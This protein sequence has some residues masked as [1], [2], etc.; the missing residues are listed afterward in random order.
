MIRRLKKITAAL[1]L[2]G[3]LLSSVVAPVLVRAFDVPSILTS[4]ENT[5]RQ[6]EAAAGVDLRTILDAAG[7]NASQ[8]ADCTT[9]A[10]LGNLADIIKN[11]KQRAL[12]AINGF[13][14]DF[15]RRI[16]SSFAYCAAANILTSPG[17]ANPA[18]DCTISIASDARAAFEEA[19]DRE[20]RQNF[21]GRCVASLMMKK[22]VDTVAA[23]MQQSGPYGQGPAW[24]TSWLN[25]PGTEAA[26]ARDRF[27]SMLVNTD[28]CPHM[29]TRVLMYFRVPKSYIDSPPPLT[30]ITGVD[31]LD[32]FPM[33]AA[34]TLPKGFTPENMAVATQGLGY[35]TAVELM[36]RPQ[37]NFEGFIDIAQ[38]EL[39][40]Q[41]DALVTAAM[42]D[43]ISGGGIKSPSDC[44]SWSPD[45]RTC[46]AAGPNKQTGGTL[47]DQNAAAI[48]AQYDWL[49]S[50]DGTQ[51][52]AIQDIRISIANRLFNLANQP[53]PLKIE[54]GREDNADSSQ[55]A[56]PSPTPDVACTGGDPRCTCVRNDESIQALVRPYVADAIARAMFT[57]SELFS[58]NFIAPGVDPRTVLQAIC[59]RLNTATQTSCIPHPGQDDEIVL[60]GG[61][62]TISVHVINSDGSI[63]TSGG[64]AVAA[65]E[66]GVQ[67]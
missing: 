22:S 36:A 7:L 41:T 33:R 1:A 30:G 53:L 29:K 42:A 57:N 51:K 23:F 34:C 16:V 45:G 55:P 35:W 47:R 37:N 65:C 12:D 43:A 66:P 46:L 4:T 25:L 67:D 11:F 64:N 21:I 15:M 27:Y 5:I 18:P 52:K 59:D 40:R 19:K 9:P 17:G 20:I 56:T 60:V 58:G 63:V 6:G 62:T 54:F 44:I 49:T 50:T 13:I 48:Q 61:A 3:T 32:P 24:V 8:Y 10:L 31:G 26:R 38:A 14:Q 28:I 2:A 39:A